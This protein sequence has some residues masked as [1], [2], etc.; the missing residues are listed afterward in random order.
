MVQLVDTI[1]ELKVMELQYFP[2]YSS[3]ENGCNNISFL[4]YTTEPPI[5]YSQLSCLNTNESTELPQLNASFSGYIS[6]T[7]ISIELHILPNYIWNLALSL[8]GSEQASGLEYGESGGLES[9]ELG[10]QGRPVRI[11]FRACM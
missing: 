5:S 3:N 2:W 8:D 9:G 7:K 10:G 11:Q 4:I 6:I 1:A